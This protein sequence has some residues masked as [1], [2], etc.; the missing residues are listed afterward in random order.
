[1]IEGDSQQ[2]PMILK[3]VVNNAAEAADDGGR[4]RISTSSEHIDGTIAAAHPGLAPGQYVCLTVED[5]GKGMDAK[6]R[7]R[8][9]EP[10][11]TTKFQGRGLGMA[12]VY[13]IIKN[14][15][16][17]V[18]VE[19]QPRQGTVVRILLPPKE[20]AS[21]PSRD[22]KTGMSGRQS[23]VLVIEDDD[24]VL[25][26]IRSLIEKM[27][28][29]VLEAASAHAAIDLVQSFEGCIDLALLDIKLP[30]MEG[31]VLFPLL[32]QARPEMKV[33]ICS[34]YSLDTHMQDLLSCGASGFLQ[35]PFTFNAIREKIREA[36]DH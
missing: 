12:A 27:G 19:S 10:F 6:T 35:K 18:Y 5:D 25:F 16:G 7:E 22:C 31:G 13:G 34:G 24:Q 11:F 36:L 14:H 32:K 21:R 2:L 28:H 17:Y 30:D 4:I 9:F 20:S 15:R 8:I 33:L 1:M 29:H 3:A 23:T 26:T